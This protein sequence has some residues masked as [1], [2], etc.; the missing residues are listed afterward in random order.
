MGDQAV[1]PRDD[2]LFGALLDRVTEAVAVFRVEPGALQ[3]QPQGEAMG[4][5]AY[6]CGHR[7]ARKENGQE[8]P[9]AD[10]H[11]LNSSAR[12]IGSPCLIGRARLAQAS[13]RYTQAPAVMPSVISRSPQAITPSAI[14]LSM[15][16]S[17]Q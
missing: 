3:V 5:R 2:A 16:P 15:M 12:M 13:S 1:P 17:P 8:K 7:A 6:L 11:H 9:C 4:D 14:L 10:A